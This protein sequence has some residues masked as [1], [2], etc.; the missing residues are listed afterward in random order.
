VGTAF[1]TLAWRNRAKYSVVAVG[2]GYAVGKHTVDV[3]AGQVFVLLFTGVG[4]LHIK[5]SPFRVF[6][7]FASFFV[8]CFIFFV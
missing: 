6:W 4:G 7:R 2:K 5:K 8:V 3:T 1:L